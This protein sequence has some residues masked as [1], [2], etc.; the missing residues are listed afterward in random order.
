M[1]A[2]PSLGAEK[3]R[4][5][6]N[7]GIDLEA[8]FLSWMTELLGDRAAEVIAEAAAEAA[9]HH[10]KRASKRGDVSG[11]AAARGAVALFWLSHGHSEESAAEHM[12]ISRETLKTHIKRTREKMGLVGGTRE[13]LVAHAIRTGIIP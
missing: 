8:S 6:A 2:F 7:H 13:L 9:A 10:P 11:A 5:Q 12:G 3:E 4:L 1:E